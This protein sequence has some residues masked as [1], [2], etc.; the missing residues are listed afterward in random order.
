MLHP[1]TRLPSV[2][3]EYLPDGFDI[4]TST[5]MA[6]SYV[7]DMF[8]IPQSDLQAEHRIRFSPT[9]GRSSDV[10]DVVLI[11]T[12]TSLDDLGYAKPVRIGEAAR[13]VYAGNI[14]D[15]AAQIGIFAAAYRYHGDAQE[16]RLGPKGLSGIDGVFPKS[17]PAVF[18]NQVVPGEEL[19]VK[20]SV[21]GDSSYGFTIMRKTAVGGSGRVYKYLEAEHGPAG[22]TLVLVDMDE[23]LAEKFDLVGVPVALKTAQFRFGAGRVIIEDFGGGAKGSESAD[24]AA[25]RELYEEFN[26]KLDI[27]EED[28]LAITARSLNTDIKEIFKGRQIDQRAD[29]MDLAAVLRRGISGEGSGYRPAGKSEDANVSRFWEWAK[30]R[31]PE[32]RDAERQYPVAEFL[33]GG[34]M[35]TYLEIMYT[36]KARYSE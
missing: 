1:V 33:N 9:C 25:R 24:E 11:T 34:G 8:G 2:S 19:V 30:D 16:L 32:F 14:V 15:G 20:E 21:K 27:S 31:T 35:S 18:K 3:G 6:T 13:Q 7:S 28:N 10:D 22:T 23:S 29:A 4:W 12:G 5:K 26:K 36:I 17:S